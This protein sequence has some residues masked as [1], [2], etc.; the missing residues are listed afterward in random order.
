MRRQERKTRSETRMQDAKMRS[1]IRR[2]DA[3]MVRQDSFMAQQDDTM[4]GSIAEIT[5]HDAG[6]ATQSAKQ[7]A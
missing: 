3:E 5:R 2:Q 4:K 1:E 7:K 6:S